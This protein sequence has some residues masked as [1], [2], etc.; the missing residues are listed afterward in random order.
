MT[1]LVGVLAPPLATDLAVYMS[2]H[3]A[4]YVPRDGYVV[5]PIVV[6]FDAVKPTSGIRISA[7]DYFDTGVLPTDEWMHCIVVALA[8]DLCPRGTRGR[9]A[10]KAE[11]AH[12]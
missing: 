12:T 5:P 2:P 10:P 1:V 9:P 7:V 3:A 4:A 8:D 11:S 6:E